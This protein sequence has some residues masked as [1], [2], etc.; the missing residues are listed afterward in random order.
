MDLGKDAV[1]ENQ[2]NMHKVRMLAKYSG[3]LLYNIISGY[4][5]VYVLRYLYN[6]G[7]KHFMI[8]EFSSRTAVTASNKL[9]LIEFTSV[10]NGRFLRQPPR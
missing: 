7:Q 3:L 8:A 5:I 2:I 6:Q 4:L 9:R 10:F 1:R